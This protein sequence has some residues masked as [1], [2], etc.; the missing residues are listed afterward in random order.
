M[1]NVTVDDLDDEAFSPELLAAFAQVK[2]A[3]DGGEQ[4]ADETKRTAAD[5][6]S[7]LQKRRRKT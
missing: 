5:H 7:A 6:L 3:K 4:V 2:A 1:L